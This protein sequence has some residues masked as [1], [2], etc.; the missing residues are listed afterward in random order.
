MCRSDGEAR[1]GLPRAAKHPFDKLQLPRCPQGRIL[2]RPRHWLPGNR[3]YSL[4]VTSLNTDQAEFY[5]QVTFHHRRDSV[6]STYIVCVVTPIVRWLCDRSTYHPSS[7]AA[8]VAAGWLAVQE[9]LS[10]RKSK[11]R[12]SSDLLLADLRHT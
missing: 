8:I 11:M 4:Y 12:K 7:T 9:M 3:L 10:N 1:G 2:R 6:W 5:V